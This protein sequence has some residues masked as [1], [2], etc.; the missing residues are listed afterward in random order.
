MIIDELSAM[1]M[2]RQKRRAA[3]RDCSVVCRSWLIRCRFYLIEEI[4]IYSPDALNVVVSMIKMFPGW[5]QHVL[6]LNIGNNQF[7]SSNARQWISWLPLQLPPLPRLRRLFLRNVDL[8]DLH[9]EF[10]RLLS[11]LTPINMDLE[12]AIPLWS[13]EHGCTPGRLASLA[14]AVHAAWVVEASGSPPFFPVYTD[15][16]VTDLRQWPRNLTSRMGFVLHNRV[17]E[18]L[19][20]LRQWRSP[21]KAMIIRMQDLPLGSD[22]DPAHVEAS[23]NQSSQ[24]WRS[25]RR[26]LRNF[27]VKSDVM[28]FSMAIDVAVRIGLFDMDVSVTHKWGELATL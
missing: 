5:S 7:G 20:M 18:P 12:L 11:R 23:R 16:E 25:I 14:R 4:S 19:P 3:L 28:T 1:K 10:P 22:W 21:V 27:V 15:K 26:I 2:S 24:V 6:I 13:M 8:S 9:P 17:E